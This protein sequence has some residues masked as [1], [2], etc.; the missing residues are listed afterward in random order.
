MKSINRILTLP[1]DLTRT[2]TPI[3]KLILASEHVRRTVPFGKKPTDPV[4]AWLADGPTLDIQGH[5]DGLVRGTLERIAICSEALQILKGQDM[6]EL[7]VEEVTAE[8]EAS[9]KTLEDLTKAQAAFRHVMEESMSTQHQW[10]DPGPTSKP[11]SPSPPLDSSPADFDIHPSDLRSDAEDESPSASRFVDDE[12]EDDLS[13]DDEVEEDE[14]NDGYEEDDFVVPDTPPKPK[15]KSQVKKRKLVLSSDDEDDPPSPAPKKTRLSPEAL[16]NRNVTHQ[17]HADSVLMDHC[18]LP[19]ERIE[20]DERMG[21]AAAILAERDSEDS[22]PQ[23]RALLGAVDK[24]FWETGV[25]RAIATLECLDTTI[26][27]TSESCKAAVAAGRYGE[28]AEAVAALHDAL[29]E[30]RTLAMVRDLYLSA[31]FASYA[32]WEDSTMDLFMKGIDRLTT[33]APEVMQ[34]VA[35]GLQ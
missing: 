28:H 15:K 7:K 21:I 33:E 13:D 25:Q 35:K 27:A 3:F 34:E 2:L 1:A 22:F 32:D 23:D 18:D 10:A 5:L 24:E 8:M 11:R 16:A 20:V 9:Q 6:E 4:E 19:I 26:G 29:N 31:K 14:D 30:R 17:D 12:A